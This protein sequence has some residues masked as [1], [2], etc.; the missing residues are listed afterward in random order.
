LETLN[1]LTQY[2]ARAV[3]HYDS[4]KDEITSYFIFKIQDILATK[5]S[6]MM[7]KKETQKSSGG[8]ENK[9]PSTQG[10]Q[11]SEKNPKKKQ[12]LFEIQQ[13]PTEEA[14]SESDEDN[15]KKFS[16]NNSNRKK[17]PGSTIAQMRN[18]KKRF[19]HL[20]YKIEDKLVTEKENLNATVTVYHS[21]TEKNDDLV[22]SDIAKQK[23]RI[24]KKLEQKKFESFASQ[25]MNSNSLQLSSRNQHAYSDILERKGEQND[26]TLEFMLRELDD[27]DECFTRR[28]EGFKGG[29]SLNNSTNKSYLDDKY[30]SRSTKSESQAMK[31]TFFQNN[32]KA[33]LNLPSKDARSQDSRNS[34]ESPKSTNLE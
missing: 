33:K 2:Y 25:T 5:K 14:N 24:Q 11:G 10:S 12:P 4:F 31:R 28:K 19:V 9:V 1:E 16:G 22:K 23:E 27:D 34:D 13:N 29:D 3:E 26:R 7:L 8:K 30:E 18:K 17:S 32:D 6:L 20:F 21:S 15:G